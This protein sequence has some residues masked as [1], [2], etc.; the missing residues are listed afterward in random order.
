MPP[1]RGSDGRTPARTGRQGQHHRGKVAEMPTR[2]RRTRLADD[3]IGATRHDGST[4]SE[5]GADVPELVSDVPE[6]VSD[7]PPAAPGRARGFITAEMNDEE[8]DV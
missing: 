2:G 3:R 8:G 4:V 7:V 5:G 6:L 1:D